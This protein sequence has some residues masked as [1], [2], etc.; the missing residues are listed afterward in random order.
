MTVVL[1]H[2]LEIDDY[3]GEGLPHLGDK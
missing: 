1:F 3:I 2:R